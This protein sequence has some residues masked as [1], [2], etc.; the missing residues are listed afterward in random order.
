ME[1]ELVEDLNWSGPAIVYS[2]HDSHEEKNLNSES[3]SSILDQIKITRLDGL[4]VTKLAQDT[5]NTFT[6]HF[7]RIVT[8]YFKVLVSVLTI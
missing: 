3:L 1:N 6:F 2:M 5:V 4:P 7:F 8:E